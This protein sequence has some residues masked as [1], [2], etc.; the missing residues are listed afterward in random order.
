MSADM[1]LK[2]N[3]KALVSWGLVVECF[4]C[5]H[6]SFLAK[7]AGIM[8]FGENGAFPEEPGIPYGKSK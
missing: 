5:P 4:V 2:L 6:I 3:L 7:S 1:I 8:V